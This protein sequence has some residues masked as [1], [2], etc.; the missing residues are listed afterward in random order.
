MAIFQGDFSQARRRFRECLAARQA[1]DDRA[2][3]AGCLA[4]FAGIAVG[5]NDP[6]RAARLLGAAARLREASGTR[7]GAVD[8]AEHG[9]YAAAARAALGKSEFAA[10]YAAGRAMS[11]EEAISFALEAPPE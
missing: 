11:I 3:I 1:T 2:G 8:R 7:E 5:E 10:A 4:G 9:R 6:A